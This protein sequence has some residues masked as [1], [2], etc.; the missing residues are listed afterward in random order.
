[1]ALKTS[2]DMLVFSTSDELLFATLRGLKGGKVKTGNALPPA[3]GK[4]GEA[5]ISP[6]PT[7]Y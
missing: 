3:Q 7:F 5:D 4:G 2:G 1:M 6:G